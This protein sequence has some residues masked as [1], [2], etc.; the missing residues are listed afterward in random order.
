MHEQL[1]PCIICGIHDLVNW[2][3][4]TY[5]HIQPVYIAFYSQQWDHKNCHITTNLQHQTLSIGASKS[6]RCNAS[7]QL[8]DHCF[9]AAKGWQA[10]R[11]TRRP[12]CVHAQQVYIWIHIN[13]Y[14][15]IFFLFF[16]FDCMCHI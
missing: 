6:F 3:Y 2:I 7:F 10:G 12:Q 1:R 11:T 8:Y 13:I 14:I 15:Y 9:R 4:N 5:I 16:C